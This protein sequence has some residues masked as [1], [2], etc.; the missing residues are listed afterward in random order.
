MRRHRRTLFPGKPTRNPNPAHKKTSAPNGANVYFTS[1]IISEVVAD[2]HTERD[3]VIVVEF[4]SWHTLNR[5]CCVTDANIPDTGRDAHRPLRVNC[6]ETDANLTI[7]GSEVGILGV[8]EDPRFEGLT[9][10]CAAIQVRA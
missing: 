5:S 8:I 1:D 10:K 7:V 9:S 4:R 2:F 3:R 6:C